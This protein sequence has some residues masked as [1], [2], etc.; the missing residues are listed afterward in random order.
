M[1]RTARLARF[2]IT[3]AATAAAAAALSAPLDAQDRGGL[4]PAALLEPLGDSWPTYSGDYTGRRYSPLTQV[5]TETAKHL[6]LAWTRE[7]DTG[8]PP[9]EGRGAPTFV[10]G[11]GAGDFTIGRQRLKGAILVVDDVLYVTAPDHV[12][13]LDARDGSERWHY[14][15]KT[16]GSIHIGNRGAALWRNALFFETP[17]NY[18]VS[19][20]ARTGAERWHVEIATFEDQ[21]FSTMAPIVVGDHV[22]VG[23]GN[24][25]DAPGFLQSFHPQTGE[26]R[27]IFHTVPMTP[28]SPGLDTWP[29]LDA[30][31]HGG[32]QVWVPGVYD[33]E[34][35]YY[36]FGTGNPTPGYTGVARPGDNLFTCTLIAVDVDTG[37]MAW[38]FQT[39]PHDT[40]D[41]DSAQTPILIDGV[42]DGVLGT[43][44]DRSRVFAY[45]QQYEFEGLLFSDVDA[46][47]SL[48]DAGSDVVAGLQ[49][50]RDL[51]ATP[52]D[53]DDGRETAPSKRIE[54]L[55]PGYRKRADG[56]IVALEAG[57]EAIRAACPRFNAWVARLEA[58]AEG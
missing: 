29:N 42:I 39:S 55:L 12:W 41:W 32:G 38:Y 10:G 4:D 30:A 23:T 22:L 21:Y 44:R 48:P 17:D 6:T 57:L 2:A 15:W 49:E 9:L 11:E 53:I 28:D 19:L 8:M 43:N 47:A 3:A 20:D 36:I 14:F 27:W 33:P 5:T 50:I 24:D 25:L 26:R 56:P 58:L 7:L 13:A 1:K 34:T 31:R 46:F 54:R 37:E 18:L 16:R 40:H 51:F 35:S 52:E 45:V